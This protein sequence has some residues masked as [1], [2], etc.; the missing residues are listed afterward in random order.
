MMTKDTSFQHLETA[1][2]GFESECNH[3]SN[4]ENMKRLSNENKTNPSYPALQKIKSIE[5]TVHFNAQEHNSDIADVQ[6]KMQLDPLKR[7]T[8]VGIAFSISPNQTDK[9]QNGADTASFHK[10]DSISPN[11]I[12]DTQSNQ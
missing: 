10:E 3:G 6:N 9:V 4:V 7:E 12:R 8:S 1:N 11:S 2:T 5:L